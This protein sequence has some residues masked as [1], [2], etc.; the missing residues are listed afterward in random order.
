M[1]YKSR[2]KN[3]WEKLDEIRY[4]SSEYV[5]ITGVWHRNEL[6]AEGYNNA[7]IDE[8]FKKGYIQLI[9]E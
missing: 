9:G 4:F 5:N 8:L 7:Q 2:I 3:Y 6:R 1:S